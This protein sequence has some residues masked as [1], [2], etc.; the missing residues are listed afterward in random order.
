MLVLAAI[1]ISFTGVIWKV[2][3]YVILGF[4][5]IILSGLAGL[6]IG[7]SQGIRVP[8]LQWPAALTVSLLYPIAIRLGQVMGYQ[9]EQ[10]QASF[11][12]AHNRLAQMSKL[13]VRPEEILVLL[14]HCL[15]WAECKIKITTDITNCQKCG[16]CKISELLDLQ[17]EYGFKMAI[18][19]GGTLARKIIKESRPKAVIGVAC[20]R[21]L[22]SG[23]QDVRQIHVVG[24]TN[25]RPFG[26]CY[27]TSIEIEK[28][29][30]TLD[31]LLI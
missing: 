25:E 23:I 31:N 22:A 8:Y 18:A 9:K 14:P 19:T 7:L 4:G 28:I 2:V 6:Y 20:E 21:D 1:V 26:P 27:N 11:I 12:S 15:Q 3:S 29:R 24:I 16:K 17:R 5:L 10:V 30:Q 13:K